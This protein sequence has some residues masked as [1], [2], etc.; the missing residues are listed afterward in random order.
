M[1]DILVRC[2]RPQHT[3]GEF[4]FCTFEELLHW[5]LKI[6]SLARGQAGLWIYELA[7]EGHIAR[8]LGSRVDLEMECSFQNYV[9]AREVAITTGLIRTRGLSEIPNKSPDVSLAFAREMD[10]RILVSSA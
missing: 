6:K 7:T 9:L 10:A 8:A 4:S 2:N 3:S 1:L 5:L